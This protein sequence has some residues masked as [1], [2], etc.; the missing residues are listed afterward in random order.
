MRPTI[1]SA[2]IVVTATVLSIGLSTADA[3]EKWHPMWNAAQWQV[4]EH[5][6]PVQIAVEIDGDVKKGGV[7]DRMLENAVELGQRRNDIPA[8]P[9]SDAKATFPRMYVLLTAIEI[10]V[11][12]YGSY[13][14][15]KIEIALQ[16]L[17]EFTPATRA[18]WRVWDGPY[19]SWRDYWTH[20]LLGYARFDTFSDMVRDALSEMLDRFSVEFLRARNEAEAA[21]ER[22]IATTD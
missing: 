2:A 7:T 20:G 15:Y 13:L 14:A 19:S 10:P 6:V 5:S 9:I 18:H 1:L 22:Q 17:D 3:N 21:H 4:G 8:E 16:C 11:G 12:E